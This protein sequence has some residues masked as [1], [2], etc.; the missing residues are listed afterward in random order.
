M[1][2]IFGDTVNL[3]RDRFTVLELDTFR[4]DH[5]D[6]TVT[7]WCVVETVP[8]QEIGILENLVKIHSDLISQYQQQNW[9]FCT[10]ALQHLKGRWNGDLDSFYC[11]LER[12]I[13]VLACDPPG[14]DWTWI[15]A[16]PGGQQEQQAEQ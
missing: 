1:Q 12:R 3:V 5:A 6:V 11:D 14:A 7:A 13:N 15:R 16:Q 2:I 4:T 8:L 9:S 10:E